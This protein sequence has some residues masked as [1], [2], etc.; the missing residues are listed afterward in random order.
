MTVWFFRSLLENFGLFDHSFLKIYDSLIPNDIY[1]KAN[2]N[3]YG[4][5]TYIVFMLAKL[6]DVPG[7]TEKSAQGNVVQQQ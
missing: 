3:A 1:Q 6:I 7:V 2:Q 4:N 5:F